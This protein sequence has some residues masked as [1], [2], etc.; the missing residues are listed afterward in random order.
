[1]N[2]RYKRKQELLNPF[3]IEDES[4]K[5]RRY[6]PKAASKENVGLLQLLNT[7]QLK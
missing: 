2:N 4:R 3:E 7:R 1:L 6:A 5:A